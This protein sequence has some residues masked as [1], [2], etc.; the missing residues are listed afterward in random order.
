MYL[1]YVMDVNVVYSSKTRPNYKLPNAIAFDLDET[2]GSFSNFHSIWA[3][4]D[5]LMKTQQ[6]FDDLMDLYPEFLRSLIILMVFGFSVRSFDV[7]SCSSSLQITPSASKIKTLLAD[8]TS[9]PLR[10]GEKL[11]GRKINTRIL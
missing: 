5:E 9:E 1:F 10:L 3:R 11:S 6:T 8:K 7:R 2:I 4:L